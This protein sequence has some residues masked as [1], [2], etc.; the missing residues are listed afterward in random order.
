MSKY[1]LFPEDYDPVIANGPPTADYLEIGCS[2][3][4]EET[5]TQQELAK[6]A[7]IIEA[8]NPPIKRWYRII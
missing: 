2:W 1:L 5:R 3:T 7:V 8:D 4:E 6:Q